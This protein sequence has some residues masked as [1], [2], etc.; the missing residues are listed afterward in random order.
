MTSGPET[1]KAPRACTMQ[2]ERPGSLKMLKPILP[3]P[4]RERSMDSLNV[5]VVFVG[6]PSGGSAGIL[7]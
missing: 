5:S 7:P 3:Q 6:P 4:K 1:P 2:R